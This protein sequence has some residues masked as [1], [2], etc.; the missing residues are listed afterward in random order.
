[1]KREL[2]PLYDME[3]VIVGHP[4]RSKDEIKKQV[5]SMGGKVITKISKSVMAVISTE[6]E[7]EKMGARMRDV[8]NCE[9]HVV[10]V[11][12]LDEAKDNAGKIP[13][14]IIKKSLCSWGT[15]VSAKNCQNLS[16]YVI[17]KK[18]Y[19]LEFSDFFFI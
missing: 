7:V 3:F 13:D 2:P 19:Q 1:M 5:A 12:F 11:E 10:P 6:E 14:L 8:E 9:I 4:P 15:D 17:F 16:I 18:M